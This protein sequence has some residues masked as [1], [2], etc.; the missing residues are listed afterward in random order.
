M[1]W[2]RYVFEDANRHL[3]EK[4]QNV[5]NIPEPHLDTTFISHLMGYASPMRL[6]GQ[7]AIKI[8]THFIGGLSQ[9]R[10]WEIADIGVFVF[11]QQAGK[12]VRQKVALLQSKR[13]YPDVGDVVELETYDYWL[14]MARLGAKQ[15]SQAPLLAQRTFS[16][17]MESAYQA[18][19]RG[20]QVD[21]IKVF[22]TRSTIPVFYLLYN[23]AKVPC[24]FKAGFSYAFQ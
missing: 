3:C 6:A 10:S 19:Q 13:L 22:Q 24:T 18:L 20:K 21:R 23:P 17:S 5:P 1:D 8:D 12:L 7:W 4:I 11:F 2:F 16:F 15:G 9:F 14:G